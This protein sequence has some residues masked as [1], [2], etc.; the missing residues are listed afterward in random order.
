MN[1]RPR[2]KMRQ[3]QWNKLPPRLVGPTVWGE[4]DEEEDE[5]LKGL[6]FEL[7]IEDLETWFHVVPVERKKPAA[8]K[9]GGAGK[10]YSVLEPRRATNLEIVLSRLKMSSDEIRSMLMDAD[11]T[12]LNTDFLAELLKMLPNDQEETALREYDGKPEALAKA[13]K[14]MLALMSVPMVRS[15]IQNYMAVG[16]F[17]SQVEVLCSD[18]AIVRSACDQVLTS[19]TL[20]AFL[21]S[22]LKIGNYCNGGTSRGN[23]TGFKFSSLAKILTTRS[24]K[25]RNFTLCDYAVRLLH[26]ATDGVEAE[27]KSDDQHDES[28]DDRGSEEEVEKEEEEEEEEEELIWCVAEL[29]KVKAASKVSIQHVESTLREVYQ[30]I[31]A[32]T[33]E[34]DTLHDPEADDVSA[35]DS[36]ARFLDS[37]VTLA[38]ER[39]AD[40]YEEL[41]DVHASFTEVLEFMAGD[42]KPLPSVQDFFKDFATIVA[43]IEASERNRLTFQPARMPSS[44]SLASLASPDPTPDPSSTQPPPLFRDPSVLRREKEESQAKQ[45]AALSSALR[46]RRTDVGSSTYDCSDPSLAYPDDDESTE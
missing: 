26:T 3:I 36:Y 11:P 16:D 25:K 32:I 9:G 5:R 44:S 27:G 18:L 15:R 24:T 8:L 20:K 29:G 38:M 30:Q 1:G 19:S 21:A 14:T 33:K 34:L 41:A 2:K 4:M 39:I 10:L 23:V 46:A 6:E 12:Q 28:D 35:D 42:Q 45:L 7:D 17:D 13:D 22:V 43:M 37:F 31:E 40:L